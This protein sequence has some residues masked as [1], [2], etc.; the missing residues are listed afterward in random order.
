MTAIL[1]PTATRTPFT[2]EAAAELSRSWA[3]QERWAGIERSYTAQEVIRLRGTRH[4]GAHPRAAGRDAAVA[5]AAHPTGH[6]RPRCPDRQ[7]GRPDGPRRAR[8]H[9]PVGL[10]GRGGRQP[11]RPDLSR[12]EPVP[13]ELGAGRG[14]AH[15][16]RA[17]AGGP[18]RAQLRRRGHRLAGAHRRR[19][20][21][22]VRRSAERL[23][24]DEADDRRRRGRG[25][26]GGPAR[27]GE[28]VRAPRWQGPRAD[29][30]STSAPSTPP[31][32]RPTSRTCPPSSS[33]APTRSP[34][35]W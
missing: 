24:A 1:E 13:V 35:T 30:P 17:A 18:D 10:A 2:S 32:W 14:P 3:G 7:P 21:G 6:P 26:L 15:Q 28:E 33:P 29:R 31:G 22:R 25:A 20:R 9:L 11:L 4:R 27:L 16:Q 8:R 34:P 23:R 5:A 12:P 19:R